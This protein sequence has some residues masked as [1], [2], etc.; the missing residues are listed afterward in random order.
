MRCAATLGLSG[1]RLL[2]KRQFQGDS[3]A[4][5]LG[6]K[7]SPRPTGQ[8]K[9]SITRH[10]LQRARQIGL[11]P[12]R[13]PGEAFQRFR[14]LLGDRAQKVAVAPRKHPSERLCRGEPDFR[15]VRR[16]LQFAAGDARSLA[17]AAPSTSCSN[18]SWTELR[19]AE[20]RSLD[21][22]CNRKLLLNHLRHLFFRS[23]RREGASKRS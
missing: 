15:R 23:G 19:R 9:E 2:R 10:G 16:R 20:F 7:P 13:D 17:A 4:G 21:L 14:V 22:H 3:V 11:A 6:A 12:A 18:A 8:T 1:V 5:K